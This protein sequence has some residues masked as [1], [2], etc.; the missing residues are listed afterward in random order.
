LAV[1]QSLDRRITTLDG[2]RGFPVQPVRD[3]AKDQDDAVIVVRLDV[4]HFA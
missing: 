1:G 4:M 2:L 3:F